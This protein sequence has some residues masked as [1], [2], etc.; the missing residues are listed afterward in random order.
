MAEGYDSGLTA[1]EPGVW[2][3][4][5]HADGAPLTHIA[6]FAGL[7]VLVLVLVLVGA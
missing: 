1:V 6:R 7:L 5:L 4:W 2:P 3:G